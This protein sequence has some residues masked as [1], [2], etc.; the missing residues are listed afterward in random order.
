MKTSVSEIKRKECSYSDQLQMISFV[1]TYDDAERQQF[2]DM[3]F[4]K[5]TTDAEL[6]RWT[7][8]DRLAGCAADIEESTHQLTE[9]SSSSNP[10]GHRS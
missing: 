2:T 9:E 6:Q 3:P 4:L 8:P 5:G 7:E 1:V 10:S